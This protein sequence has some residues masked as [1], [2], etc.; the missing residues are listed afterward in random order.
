MDDS[1]TKEEQWCYILGIKS[2]ICE[3]EATIDS[4][5]I[6]KGQRKVKIKLKHPTEEEFYISFS[7]AGPVS[8]NFILEP[9]SK[10][11]MKIV[12]LLQDERG[13]II[14]TGKGSEAYNEDRYF[15]KNIIKPLSHKIVTSKDEDSIEYYNQE[16]ANKSKQFI[17]NTIH[18][19]VAWGNFISLKNG[20]AGFRQDQD[21]IEKLKNFI[22]K[23]YP[24]VR[25]IQYIGRKDS[26]GSK[27]SDVACRRFNEI[28]LKRS[29]VLKQDT[30]LGAKI[31][32]I[33]SNF[34]NEP[35]SIQDIRQEYVLVDFW[36]SWCKP[37]R[38]EVPYLKEVARKYQDKLNIY[39]V[40]LDQNPEAWLKAIQ[41]DNTHEFT[42]TIGSNSQGLPNFRVQ[43][44]GIKSIPANFLLNKERCII[45][46]DLRGKELI[47]IIDSVM[48]KE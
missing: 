48:Q 33:F 31:E 17:I 47:Q 16:L 8:K 40:S 1:F 6:K 18:P 10:V 30:S 29:N 45:A 9:H 7:E 5:R 13:H 26:P 24:N 35:I 15:R 22:K 20:F 36:A 14:M 46:K 23:K 4:V 37:C 43:G 28:T 41:T 3:N 38:Q 27:L 32:L 34:K 25:Y 44:L 39:A 21:T 19:R 42:H 12:P 2:W 11:Q